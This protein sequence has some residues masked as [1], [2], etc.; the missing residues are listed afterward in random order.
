[1]IR[2]LASRGAGPG[3]GNDAG[4]HRRHAGLIFPAHG[5]FKDF[6]SGQARSSPSLFLIPVLPLG[7]FVAG[8]GNALFDLFKC[9]QENLIALLAA[10]LTIIVVAQTGRMAGTQSPV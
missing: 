4:H 3:I 6:F 10:G 7:N 8:A 5:L 9:L 2:K 1:M